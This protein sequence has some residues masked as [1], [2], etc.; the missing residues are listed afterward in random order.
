V[1]CN[2][3]TV[4]YL[5]PLTQDDS[6]FAYD[7]SA[8]RLRPDRSKEAFELYDR[9]LISAEACRRENGFPEDDAPTAAQQ[10][11][12][13][14]LKVATGSS[15]P[16]QVGA[17][18]KM[19]GVILETPALPGPPRETPQPPSLMDHPTRPRTPAES[20]LLAAADA[21][22]FRALE[23]AGNRLRTQVG[24]PPGVPAYETH[25]LVPVN[26]NADLLLTDAWSCAD[27][28]LDGIADPLAIVP[29]LH[30]YAEQVLRSGRP[31]SKANLAK[32]LDQVRS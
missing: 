17:A 25:T 3:L 30:A 15:T 5:R 27:K 26:G 13:L 29:V 4:G 9:G 1:I 2:A 16:D 22:V 11:Q 7:T 19:L 28:V 23:R 31:H 8:L 18:L 6:F 12:W 20:A 14:L 24:K 32:W 21:L 10:T